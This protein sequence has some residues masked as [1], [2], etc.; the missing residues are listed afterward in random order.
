MERQMCVKSTKIE[1]ERERERERKVKHIHRNKLYNRIHT[2]FTGGS[3]LLEQAAS[4]VES[5]PEAAAAS[6]ATETAA[7]GV[8]ADAAS[9]AGT[10]SALCV[11][12]IYASTA[13]C[14]P[15]VSATHEDVSG[16][17]TVTVSTRAG[18]TRPDFEVSLSR[19]YLSSRNRNLCGRCGSGWGAKEGQ[20][21]AW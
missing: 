17:N 7:T 12:I 16:R 10:S 9:S 5:S 11:L 1:G 6:A 14:H 21:W 18:S 15:A 3:L 19:L 2:L 13:V 20:W 8:V 4:A